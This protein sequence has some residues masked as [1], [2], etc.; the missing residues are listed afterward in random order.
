MKIKNI[1]TGLLAG[2]LILSCLLTSCKDDNDDT[3]ST[4][5]VNKF[6][7][8]VVVQGRKS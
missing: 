5:V 1:I 4:L 3:P 2:C 7:L 6:Y 8:P